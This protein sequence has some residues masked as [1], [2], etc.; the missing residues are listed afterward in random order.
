[1]TSSTSTQLEHIFASIE[2]AWTYADYEELSGAAAIA[3]ARKFI[4]AVKRLVLL[5]PEVS[6]RGAPE[7][8]MVRMNIEAL[9]KEADNAR[10]LITRLHAAS[11][12][13]QFVDLTY[14]RD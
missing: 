12:S 10:K 14:Y 6:S 7:G 4:T 2:S 13:T 8:E 5:L 11:S 3:R 9:Q 1:M